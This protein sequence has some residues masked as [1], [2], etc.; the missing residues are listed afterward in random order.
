MFARLPRVRPSPRLF[1]LPFC[2]DAPG[3]PSGSR[4]LKKAPQK[5]LIKVF[6]GVQGGGFSK[7]PP[8][9]GKPMI[10]EELLKLKSNGKEGVLVTVVEKDGHGPAVP[11]AK[12]LVA[13]GAR[14]CGTV[15]GGSLEYAAINRAARV[16][17]DKK[18]ILQKYLLSQD[19]Q[20][21][22]EDAEK[23]GMICGGS[24]TLF[25]EYIGW[26]ERLYLFGAGHVG[27]ALVY[28]LKNL[29][30]YTTVLDNREG[31]VETIDGV[32]RRATVDYSSAL[33]GEDV[34]PG[35][36]FI[37]AAHSHALDY[38]IL[39][40]IYQAGWQPKYIGMVASKRKA[41]AMVRQL[42]EEVSED[43]DLDILYAPVGLDI[44]GQAP[45]EIAI[46]IISEIQAV[47][48]GKNGHKHMKAK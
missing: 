46:S 27:K 25:F 38:V 21:I 41:P 3:G 24:I 47:R 22:D 2:F 48:F 5:L 30:Y 28:H 42:K 1:C 19:N 23:T 18:S 15:G 16:L 13:G 31:M 12:M 40:R 37:I 36:F 44:G 34:P 33:E 20:I 10:Y 14:Q 8:W 39:K 9:K 17:K 4:F 7:K 45:G 35:G 32:Q 11:G 26:G 6:R 43:V 29:N